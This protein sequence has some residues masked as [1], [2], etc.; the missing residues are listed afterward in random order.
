M[1]SLAF[2]INAQSKLK[3]DSTEWGDPQPQS[4]RGSRRAARLLVDI[5]LD[6]YIHD[7][8]LRVFT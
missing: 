4:I 8:A 7:V 3:P 2:A 1:V 6:S 5:D